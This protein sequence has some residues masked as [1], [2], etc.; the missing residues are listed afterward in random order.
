MAAERMWIEYKSGQQLLMHMFRWL[1]Y[2]KRVNKNQIENKY[3][4]AREGRV[5]G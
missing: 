1:F 5:V 4:I 2:R 3:Y